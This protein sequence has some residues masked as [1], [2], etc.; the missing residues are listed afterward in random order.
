MVTIKDKVFGEQI[1]ELKNG[2][3]TMDIPKLD[4]KGERLSQ[5]EVIDIF[6][7]D[8]NW[9]ELKQKYFPMYGFHS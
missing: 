5:E 7:D 8:P 4:I 9:K 2:V 3:W 6:K 1:F